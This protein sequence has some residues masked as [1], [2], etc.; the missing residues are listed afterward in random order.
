MKLRWTREMVD[1]VLAH[2]NAGPI[3]AI[4]ED[5][6]SLHAALEQA[7]RDMEAA[8]LRASNASLVRDM[9]IRAEQGAVER[10]RH[11][12]HLLEAERRTSQALRARTEQLEALT[13]IG[14]RDGWSREDYEAAKVL[15][16]M[17]DAPEP[18][19]PPKT[20]TCVDHPRYGVEVDGGCPLHGCEKG[21]E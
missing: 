7:E 14:L 2:G 3:G 18:A 10:A 1:G 19:D 8:L 5:W 12:Y 4:C 16:G 17:D 20:C 15:M 6:L 11:A 13:R 9:H 21:D